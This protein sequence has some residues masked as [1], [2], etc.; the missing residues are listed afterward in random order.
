MGRR[1]MKGKEVEKENGVVE[2]KG[3]VIDD[4]DK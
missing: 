4:K 3:G 2:E 1:V